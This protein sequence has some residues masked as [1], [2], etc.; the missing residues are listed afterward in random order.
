MLLGVKAAIQQIGQ[1]LALATTCLV[2]SFASVFTLTLAANL[3]PQ[4]V[5]NMLIGDFPEVMITA[6]DDVDAA[7]LSDEAGKVPGVSKAFCETVVTL[8]TDRGKHQVRRARRPRG[9]ALHPGR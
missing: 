3:T 9:L 1:N 7:A 6:R 8:K 4:R 5:V 2:L